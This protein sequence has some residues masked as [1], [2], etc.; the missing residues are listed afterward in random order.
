[1]RRIVFTGLAYLGRDP[2]T[3]VTQINTLLEPSFGPTAADND[4]FADLEDEESVAD[5]KKMK[6]VWRT[7]ETTI[8]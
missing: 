4:L 2:S 8:V 5:L 6:K 7:L 1:M 3:L